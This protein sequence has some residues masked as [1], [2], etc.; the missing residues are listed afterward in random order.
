[1]E[2]VWTQLWLVKSK[3]QNRH[4]IVPMPVSTFGGCGE[5]RLDE[6][7]G[8]WLHPVEARVRGMEQSERQELGLGSLDSDL[9]AH[10]QL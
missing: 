2:E 1:L 3:C 5:Q 4:D 8:R 7:L 10:K 6:L 9:V